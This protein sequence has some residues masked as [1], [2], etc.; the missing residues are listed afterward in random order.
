MFIVFL[1]LNLFWIIILKDDFKNFFYF[2]FELENL[3]DGIKF[4]YFFSYL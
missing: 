3:V 2:I 4:I 1:K